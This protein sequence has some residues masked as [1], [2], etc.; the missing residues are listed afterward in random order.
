MSKLD[1]EVEKR[2]VGIPTG[3]IGKIRG[4]YWVN[5]LLLKRIT[6]A[7]Q[8]VD[9]QTQFTKSYGILTRTVEELKDIDTI[10]EADANDR[11]TDRIGSEI[12]KK[13]AQ[14]ELD[15]LNATPDKKAEA[16]TKDATA[17]KDGTHAGIIIE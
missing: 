17:A 5:K 9:A 13:K 8:V 11:Q 14:N 1:R 3:F 4:S 2:S 16:S 15:A 12:R 6:S 7:T 10:L